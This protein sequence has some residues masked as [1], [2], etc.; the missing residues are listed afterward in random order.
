MLAYKLHLLIERLYSCQIC[1]WIVSKLYLVT[2][3][4]ALCAPIEISH[5]NR[6]SDFACN[7]MESCLPA[8]YRLA[9]SFWCQSK[10]YD[11][12]SLHLLDDTEGYVAASLSVYRNASHL[13]EKPSE[14]SPEQFSLDHAVW[15][16]AYGYIVKVRND[17]VPY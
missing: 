2:S 7:C 16:A 14:R 5:I 3:A 13:S 6:T 17:K 8:L 11:L 12:L 4:D 10:V 15:F 1:L 9:G